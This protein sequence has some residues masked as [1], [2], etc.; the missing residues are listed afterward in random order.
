MATSDL[1]SWTQNRPEWAKRPEKADKCRN[2]RLLSKLREALSKWKAVREIPRPSL[3]NATREEIMAVIPRD[4]IGFEAYSRY[5]A[6]REIVGEEAAEAVLEEFKMGGRLSWLHFPLGSI[7]WAE[8][9][10][11]R[12]YDGV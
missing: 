9:T 5:R 2:D 6:A 10:L 12:F 11:Q 7:N 1:R 8:E 4:T 3:E